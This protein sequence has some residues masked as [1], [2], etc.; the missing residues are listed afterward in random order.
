MTAAIMRVVLPAAIGIAI[1]AVAASRATGASGPDGGALGPSGALGPTGAAVAYQY[2]SDSF[3]PAFGYDSN[4]WQVEYATCLK[5]YN[6]TDDPA[7][8]GHE[9]VPEAATALPTVSSNGTIY[10]LTVKS[11]LQFSDGST[12]TADSFRRA[13]ERTQ[14]IPGAPGYPYVSDISGVQVTGDRKSTRLNSSHRL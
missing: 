9:L 12:V 3:D 7:P 11:G 8:A 14:G 5:L 13:I 6:F 10:T 4:A 2:F 1:I